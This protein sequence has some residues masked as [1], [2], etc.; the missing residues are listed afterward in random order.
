M[1]PKQGLLHRLTQLSCVVSHTPKS[2]GIAAITLAVLAV[3]SGLTLMPGLN[4][5]NTPVT[6]VAY[7]A[8]GGSITVHAERQIL[9]PATGHT[10]LMSGVHI[11]MD[12]TVINGSN[13]DIIVTDGK[14]HNVNVSGGAQVVKN[15]GGTQ[16][17]INAQNI[18]YGVD[19]NSMTATGD[20]TTN[21]SGGSEG[22]VT[23]KSDSQTLDQVNNVMRAIGHVRVDK[24][25]LTAT[26]P[27]AMILMGASGQAE[28][29]VFLG[30]AALKSAEKKMTAQKI[31]IVLS[32]GDIFAENKTKSVI[33]NKDAKG[34]PT[35]MT[36]ESHLQELDKATGMLIAN[37]QAKLH[38]E[39]TL[40][41]GPKAVFYM[42]N[43]QLDHITLS[44]GR[45]E[46]QDVDR[47][48]KGDSVLI[49]MNPKQF[50]AKG[51]VQTFIKPK[52]QSSSPKSA[53]PAKGAAAKGPAKPAMSKAASD[54]L[55]IEEAAQKK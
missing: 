14:A 42:K 29:V 36:V 23:I 28:K 41:K 27:E 6:L 22:S 50:S 17:T 11:A 52:P 5:A 8:G 10:Q 26:S 19:N 34:K 1:N 25:D 45:C 33:T 30:G 54:E 39:D 15:E 48:V 49:T 13:A 24:E 40:A 32:T 21:I 43:N 46:V 9:E 4:S 37:G 55:M 44:G 35:E 51:N 53:T 12:N 2:V 47:V 7:G 16:R 31:T 3:G 38:F 20:V 18:Q